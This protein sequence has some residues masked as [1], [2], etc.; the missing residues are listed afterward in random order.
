M[1]Q[2]VHHQEVISVHTATMG[3]LAANT[4]WLELDW[5]PITPC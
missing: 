2:I 1:F 5:I 4:M 3:C